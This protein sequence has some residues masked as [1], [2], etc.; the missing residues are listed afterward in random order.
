MCAAYQKILEH[1]PIVSKMLLSYTRSQDQ[2]NKYVIGTSSIEERV[3]MYRSYL[4]FIEVVEL[5]NNLLKA[6][7]QFL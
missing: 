6:R 3:V 2:L 1:K 7:N 4:A 5:I